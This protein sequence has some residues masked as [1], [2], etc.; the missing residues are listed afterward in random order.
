MILLPGSVFSLYAHK[1][2]FTTYS[3][4]VYAFGRWNQSRRVHTYPI[5]RRLECRLPSFHMPWR[6]Q[7]FLTLLKRWIKSIHCAFCSLS[8]LGD[9]M[10]TTS[11]CLLVN[12]I[13]FVGFFCCCFCCCC[14]C[15]GVHHV[16][17]L[18]FITF[19]FA[20]NQV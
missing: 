9:L 13:L 2:R 17:K 18:Y 10:G 15:R 8:P 19:T 5:D 7:L 16:R 3:N 6:T 1:P 4:V 14:Y 20:V 12:R 11:W